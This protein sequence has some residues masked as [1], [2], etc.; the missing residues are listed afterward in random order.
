MTS[1]PLDFKAKYEELFNSQGSKRKRTKRDPQDAKAA[2]ETE[3][4]SSAA[5]KMAML[6]LQTAHELFHT[7]SGE[8]FVTVKDGGVLKHY[9]VQGSDYAE[10]LTRLNYLEYATAPAADAVK[11]ASNI[12]AGEAKYAGAEHEVFARIAHHEGLIWVDLGDPTWRAVRIDSHGWRVVD[13]AEVPVKFKR[14]RSTRALPEPQSG[15]SLDELRSLFK[16]EDADWMIIPGWLVG[17]FQE[18]GGRAHLELIGQQGSG[19]ST[20][21]RMLV[22]IVDPTDILLRSVPRN[23]ED[24]MIAVQSRTVIGFDNVSSL[25]PEM[26]DNFCRLSTGGGF[27]TRKLYAN[28]EEESFTAQQPAL[29]TSIVPI[30]LNRPDLQERTVTARLESLANETYRSERDINAEFAV[31]L[32]RLTGALYSAVSTALYHQDTVELESRP[33]LA[34]FA[35]WVEAASPAF[36]W[37]VGDFSAALEASNMM[38]NVMAVDASPIGRLVYGFMK[39]QQ[40]WEGS[41]SDLLVTI[42]ELASD[43]DKRQRQFPKDSARL[44]VQL[45]RMQ[46]PLAALGVWVGFDRSRRANVVLLDRNDEVY[47]KD[48]GPAAQ[49][50]PDATAQQPP[51]EP[52]DESGKRCVQCRTPIPE[53]ELYC[54]AHRGTNASVRDW[55]YGQLEDGPKFVA[56]VQEEAKHVGISQNALSDARAALNVQTIIL[57][58]QR[59]YTLGGAA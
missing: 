59:H 37:D 8:P 32:P 20:F 28:R 34:D 53:S 4:K 10:H 43:D 1:P 26:A 57:D 24:L 9:A 52:P 42:R 29:W 12:V 3:A 2:Q 23:E 6:G 51:L 15:G 7:P 22:R 31:M 25:H 30:T 13:S 46:R 5:T 38:A 33:R 41:V 19:K 48:D 35:T 50:D 56:D 17:V 36:G 54:P 40:H 11:A 47:G 18:D 44:G 55:L 21:A 49:P 14:T 58:K 45:R 27:A 39:D 16:I